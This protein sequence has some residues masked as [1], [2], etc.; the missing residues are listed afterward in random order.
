[1]GERWGRRCASAVG[2]GLTL[3]L[4]RLC[5]CSV[6]S[7]APVSLNRSSV[8]TQ[9]TLPHLVLKAREVGVEVNLL[10]VFIVVQHLHGHDVA[11]VAQVRLEWAGPRADSETPQRRSEGRGG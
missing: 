5:P 3:P 8:A 9:R 10:V 6:S 11:V 7:A 4:S 1:M 2:V